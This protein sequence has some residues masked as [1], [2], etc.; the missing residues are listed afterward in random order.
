M[1]SILGGED[2]RKIDQGLDDPAAE[3]EQ[4]ASSSEGDNDEGG[5][6]RENGKT[7]SEHSTSDNDKDDEER[8][9]GD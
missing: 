3:N 2:I 1:A 6:T 4:A 5:Q 9:K 7:D 8:G